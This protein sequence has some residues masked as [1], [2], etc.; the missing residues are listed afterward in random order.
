MKSNFDK[1]LALVFKEEGGYVWDKR[2]PGGETNM[3]V[4]RSAWQSYLGKHVEDGEMVKL[5]KEQVTPFY[6][7]LYWDK[8]YGD[9]LP[10]GLD[11]LA[12]DFAVN[13]GT[14]RS[15]LLLQQ[16]LG[17]TADGVIGPVTLAVIN[18]TPINE[19]I[20]NFSEQ[21]EKYYRGLKLFP[22]FGNGWMNR[23]NRVKTAA[24]A[25]VV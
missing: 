11:Y 7:T 2:D 1:S 12:F 14:K 5:T 21:K 13:A 20:N 18:K 17:V 24:K 4:T 9:D 8:V 19:L 23:L 22:V 15:I 10:Y 16:S 3:G 6:R 25:M